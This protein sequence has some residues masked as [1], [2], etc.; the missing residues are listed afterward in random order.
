MCLHVHK[1]RAFGLE[2]P[3]M[4]AVVVIC[5]VLVLSVCK[6]LGQFLIHRAAKV[7]ASSYVQ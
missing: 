7:E 6:E 5:N 1:D 2:G 4:D 3:L